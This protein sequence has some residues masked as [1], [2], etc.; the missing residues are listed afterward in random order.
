MPKVGRVGA[1]SFGTPTPRAD[2]AQ[3]TILGNWREFLEPL[4][5]TEFQLWCNN[6]FNA[7][8]FGVAI[9]NA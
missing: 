4:D 6:C 2:L 7:D 1:L 9:S 3:K 5:V 8:I